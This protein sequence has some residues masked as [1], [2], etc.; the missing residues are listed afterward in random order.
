MHHK[1]GDP[2]QANSFSSKRRAVRFAELTRRFPDLAAM[3]VLDLGGVP[4]FWRSAPVRP[5]FVT[6]MN[7][8]KYEPPEPWLE[9]VVADACGL[10]SL[11]ACRGDYDL[12]V[13][14]SLIEHVGGYQRRRDFADVVRAA[15]PS[16]WV[17]TPDRY[18][19]VEPHYVAPGF[20]FLPLRTRARLVSRWPLAHERV[21][22]VEEA[23][24]QILTIDLISTTELA[25]L[26][27]ASDIWHERLLGFSKS[28]VAVRTG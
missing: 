17:Q 24:E 23:V 14:N 26:F 27:P 13:S 12:V 8:D 10:G 22:T 3:R 19:P 4:D 15:A 25:H 1:L 21:H 2:R 18:F 11:D 28:I 5:S 7:L 9:H 20:Q 6:T 16:H